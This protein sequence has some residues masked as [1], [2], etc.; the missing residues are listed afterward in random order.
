MSL[1]ID[2]K[3]NWMFYKVSKHE[4]Q[5]T[6][7]IVWILPLIAPSFDSIEERNNAK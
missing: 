1:S 3:K 2:L 5:F 4:T 6:R 7:S